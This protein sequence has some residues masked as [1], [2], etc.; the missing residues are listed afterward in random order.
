ML[1]IIGI[2]A[3]IIIIDFSFSF[4]KYLNDLA[5]SLSCPTTSRRFWLPNCEAKFIE[6]VGHFWIFEHLAEMLEKLV[7]RQ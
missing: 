1:I 2:I 3:L 5:I 4:R 6:G 7:M